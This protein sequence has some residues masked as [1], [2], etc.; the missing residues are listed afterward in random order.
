MLPQ[1]LRITVPGTLG[2]RQPRRMRILLQRRLRSRGRRC[3]WQLQ[4][5]VQMLR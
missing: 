1:V 2:P 4:A 3:G 5:R